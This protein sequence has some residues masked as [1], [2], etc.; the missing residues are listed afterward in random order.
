MSLDNFYKLR[1]DFTL[2]GLTG[3]MG[4]GCND[5]AEILSSSD[6]P[7]SN[8]QFPDD[9]H[10]NERQKFRI[11]KDFVTNEKNGWE[12][13][14]LLKYKDVLLLF[15]LAELA[16]H[17][18]NE[19][20]QLRLNIILPLF[21][22][23]YNDDAVKTTRIGQENRT[24]R[25]IENKIL[26][27]LVSKKNELE[28]YFRIFNFQDSKIKIENIDNSCGSD[29]INPKEFNHTFFGDYSVFCKEFYKLIDEVDPLARQ[30][31]L[32]DIA[33]NLRSNGTVFYSEVQ[34][35]ENIYTVAQI[36][37]NI[38]KINK[39]AEKKVR[40]IIDSLKN[41]LEI[42]FF[43]E[44]YSGFYLIS[45]NRDIKEV[46]NHL[47]DK[48]SIVFFNKIMKDLSLFEKDK[49][50]PVVENLI[51]LDNA[52]YKIGD[53][54][55]GNFTN[56]DIENCIQKADYYVFNKKLEEKSLSSDNSKDQISI[57]EKFT[58]YTLEMQLLKLIALIHKP[59][60]ITPNAMERTM[61]L[62]FSSKYNSGCIS[63]QV[64]AVVTD[65]FYSVKSIGWNEVPQ[66]QT[67]CSLRNVTDLI[68]GQNHNI[69]TEYE[70]SKGDYDG[71]T[72]R[73]KTEEL[74][75]AGKSI[76]DFKNDLNGHNCPFCFKELHN[77]FEGK[78]NQVHT[79]SLHAEENAMLQISKYGGQPLKG[80]NL[81]T[82]ASPCEL[83]SKKAYQLGIKNIFYIDPYPGI[84]KTQILK[85]GPKDPNLY[86][87]QGA[88]GRGFFKLFE[89]YMSIKDE[90]K[91][92]SKLKPVPSQKVVAKQL[93]SIFAKNIDI[94]K[95]D[96]L[97]EYLDGLEDDHSIVEKMIELMNDG[98]SVKKGTNQE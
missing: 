36:I 1:S 41:S 86:M 72:F 47:L 22:R 7:F 83:C 37:K 39:R 45:S 32:Q 21:K 27:F 3:R 85:A 12:R 94:T 56:P 92:R 44:R 48:I 16:A 17:V 90:T 51:D 54:K 53:F 31:F 79:R 28:N 26:P 67:P 88:V 10:L 62:A 33:C 59:G 81:F 69:F 95:N 68:D 42:N 65:E 84:S 80:G 97:I 82:T 8:L 76:A 38:I 15:F 66:G 77:A 93:K 5:I 11:C 30:L 73:T 18:D 9:L 60:I 70:K 78:D 4:G 43:K 29:I 24:E 6:N 64:G 61:Q 34:N 87:F 2:I 58:Y 89:P 19:V 14:K 40:L 74:I 55:N 96:K 23:V 57:E 20:M 52:H 25:I 13:F 46:K 35:A 50:L 98:L 63:R 91:L 71:K 75:P 49:V